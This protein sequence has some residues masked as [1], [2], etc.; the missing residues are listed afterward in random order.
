MQ[1]FANGH[2]CDRL[3]VNVKMGGAPRPLLNWR[4]AI[5]GGM[6]CFQCETRISGSVLAVNQKQDGQC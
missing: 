6:H 4:A 1:Y 3:V 2:V 5:L